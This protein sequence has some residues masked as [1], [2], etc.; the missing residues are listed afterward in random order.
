VTG[1]YAFIYENDTAILD[2]RGT[3]RVLDISDETAPTEI[4]ADQLDTATSVAGME[5][6]GDYIYASCAG[7]V[8]VIDVSEYVAGAA[9]PAAPYEV[10]NYHTQGSPVDLA[11]RGDY[12]YAINVAGD[13]PPLLHQCERAR[14]SCAARASAVG[15]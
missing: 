8:T 10:A 5:L 12:V 7:N 9:T 15:R 14:R 13:G 1:D 2:G 11:V 6:V 4:V 3:L